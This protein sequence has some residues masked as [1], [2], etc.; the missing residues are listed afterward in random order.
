MSVLKTQTGWVLGLIM[1]LVATSGCKN[2][3]VIAERDRL[4]TQNQ[5]LQQE[6]DRCRGA[7]DAAGADNQRLS[8]DVNNLQIELQNARSTK[9]TQDTSVF[10]NIKGTEIIKGR[11][12]I[13]VRVPGDML[14]ASGKISLRS[15]SKS[16]LDSIAS[17]INSTYSG[18]VVRVVGYTD[19]D[20]IK[21]SKWKD[22]LQLSMERAAAVHRYLQSRGMRPQLLEA[23]GNGQWHPR[24]SKAK[25]RRVEIVVVTAN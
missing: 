10:D 22:N 17:V 15:A 16:T 21:K 1:V 24:N 7:L 11:G 2:R 9:I 18:K 25:S 23:V 6:L 19:T 4:Y 20:P 8:A 13:T 5:N 12:T 14:F 3:E